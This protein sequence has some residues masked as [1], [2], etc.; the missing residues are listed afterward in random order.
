MTGNG[1]PVMLFLAAVIAHIILEISCLRLFLWL[2]NI[3][4]ALLLL[5]RG[6]TWREPL[7]CRAAS[8]MRHGI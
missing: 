6:S 4:C 1:I 5:G 3:V 8:Y 7:I 2:W